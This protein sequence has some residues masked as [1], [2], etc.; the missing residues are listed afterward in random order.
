MQI[1]V[2]CNKV[3]LQAPIHV[4]ADLV[5]ILT[6]PIQS[7]CLTRCKGINAILLKEAACVEEGRELALTGV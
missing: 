2:S 6:D 1:N 3:V 7:R 4:S 5:L